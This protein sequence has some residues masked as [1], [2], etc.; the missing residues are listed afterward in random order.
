M[1][2]ESANEELS[3]ELHIYRSK[4]VT[5]DYCNIDAQVISV[6]IRQPQ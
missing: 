5:L 4:R 1:K 3:R 2:L 6:Y